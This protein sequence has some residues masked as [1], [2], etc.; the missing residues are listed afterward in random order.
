VCRNGN[1]RKARSPHHQKASS[2]SD[3][4]VDWRR[5]GG[6]LVTTARSF[7]GLEAAIVIAYGL[8]GFGTFFT[9]TDLYVAWTRARHRLIL[10]ATCVLLLFVPS[11][12]RAALR[13][14][15]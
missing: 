10:I 13:R 15:P 8:A 9:P 14:V 11:N 6:V 2:R 5:G 3:D 1:H 7:K 4:A 12:N